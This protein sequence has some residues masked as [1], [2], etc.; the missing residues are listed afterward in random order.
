MML[1]RLLWFLSSTYPFLNHQ[2]LMI[3]CRSLD[4]LASLL[5]RF[6]VDDLSNLVGR[7]NSDVFQKYK[8]QVNFPVF[9]QIFSI[10]FFKS[11]S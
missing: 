5:F 2:K 7:Y 3:S 6:F 9:F 1:T 11:T 4:L 8:Q 10:L